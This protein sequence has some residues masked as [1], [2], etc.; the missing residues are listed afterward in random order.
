MMTTFG[1]GCLLSAERLFGLDASLNLQPFN[2]KKPSWIG[3]KEKKNRVEEFEK[4]FE[5]GSSA[6]GRQSKYLL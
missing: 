1:I 6:S 3:G 2:L 5:R 4:K